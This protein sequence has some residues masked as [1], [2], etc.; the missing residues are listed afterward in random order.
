MDNLLALSNKKN[1][2]ISFLGI[3]IC[4]MGFWFLEKELGAQI[5]D[6]LPGYDLALIEKNFLIY[7]EE[8]RV[9][10]AWA[11]LTLDLLFPICYV[12]FFIGLILLLGG[13][14]FSRWL[15][16]L[17]CLLGVIDIIENIQICLMLNQYP[18]ISIAQV[19][20]ANTTTIVKHSLTIFLYV[21]I[22]FLSIF[23]IGKKILN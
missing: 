20:I 17:P 1:L 13:S 23:K 10:Y 16:I 8:G 18:Y 6:V 5:L 19:E 2:A 9:L 3:L 22:I 7:G 11:S 4:L 21:C 14:S 12:V 15:V